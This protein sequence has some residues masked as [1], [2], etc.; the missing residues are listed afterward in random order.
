MKVTVKV[1]LN[2]ANRF[3]PYNDGDSLE[4]ALSFESGLP[5]CG[6]M[7]RLLEIVFEQLNMEPR[8]DWAIDYR[9]NGHR[10]LSVGDVVVIGEQA[11]ACD[12]A[13]WTAVSVRADQVWYH[14][15]ALRAVE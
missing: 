10:S 14:H 1:L 7:S 4:Q 6:N 2:R 13:G 9:A 11:Y 3:Q 12:R 15:G 8:T 5:A